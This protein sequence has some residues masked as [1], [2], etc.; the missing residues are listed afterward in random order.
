LRNSHTLTPRAPLV[1]SLD[2]SGEK[3]IEAM[4]ES[5][6]TLRG[7][8]VRFG[9]VQI[10]TPD[11]LPTARSDPSREKATEEY[12][13][14]PLSPS[15]PGDI[16][17]LDGAMGSRR[18]HIR[19]V[20]STVVLVANIVPSG[21]IASAVTVQ[22]WGNMSGGALGLFNSKTLTVW[23]P[24]PEAKRFP[25]CEKASEVTKL[26]WLEMTRPNGLTLAAC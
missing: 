12:T 20:R 2:P 21:E 24:P 23:S 15:F 16:S 9:K 6:S 26:L 14:R 18:F 1:A 17:V 7:E 10:N 5:E 4:Y 11:V 13:F 8:A 25:S 19:T 3:A 22:G